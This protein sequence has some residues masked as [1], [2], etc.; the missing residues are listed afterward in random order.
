MKKLIL[1]LLIAVSYTSFSQTKDSLNI[2]TIPSSYANHIGE[3]LT[4]KK[5]SL[6]LFKTPEV[7][8]VNKKSFLAIKNVYESTVNKDQMTQELVKRYAQALRK[9]IDL[10]RRLK[11]NFSESDSLDRAV[12]ERTQLTL[13]NTQ[14][15][16]DLTLNSL[17]KA[18]KSLEIAEKATKRERR[19]RLFEKILIG[20]AGI[21]AGILVGVSL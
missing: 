14:K 8:L 16:L 12:Y 15:A 9:N 6:Y 11:I 5:D 20:A 19:K 1:F 21:G 7:Y 10:E 18:N 3:P 2:I 13:A 4:V 17:E